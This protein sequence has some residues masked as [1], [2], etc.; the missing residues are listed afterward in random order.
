MTV[1]AI[2]IPRAMA[3]CIRSERDCFG[4]GRD[5]VMELWAGAIEVR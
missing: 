2:G 5:R 3:L 4:D 1:A